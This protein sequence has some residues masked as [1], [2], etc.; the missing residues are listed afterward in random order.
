MVPRVP[1]FHCISL[2]GIALTDQSI[3]CSI[4]AD[5]FSTLTRRG[6]T[7]I[8]SG[9]PPIYARGVLIPS[10]LKQIFRLRTAIS[11]WPFF[12]TDQATF[13]RPRRQRGDLRR[14]FSA[15]TLL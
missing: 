1:N 12:V 13:L 4:Q 10:N 3:R 6:I 9:T 5:G 8:N 15:A 2:F 14:N 7:D 11:H